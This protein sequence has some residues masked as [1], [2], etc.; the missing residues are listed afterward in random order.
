MS[1][2]S[3]SGDLFRFVCVGCVCFVTDFGTYTLLVKY[4][5]LHPGIGNLIS[6]PLGGAV[7]FFLHKFWTF[8]NRGK[9]MIHVQ[10]IRF[11]CVWAVT[12]TI[13]ELLVVF[14]HEVMAFHPAVTKLAAEGITGLC[15]FVLQRHWT[16]R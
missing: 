11:C 4:A 2:A 15:S 3:L 10:G 8:R 14:F 5:G 16:F 1:K 13:S 7:G 6:R 12:F 9:H